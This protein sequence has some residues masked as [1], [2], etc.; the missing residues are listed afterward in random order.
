M[1]KQKNAVPKEI[2]SLSERYATSRRPLER[3]FEPSEF[4]HPVDPGYPRCR[5][6][7]ENMCLEIC[8]ALA[9]TARMTIFHSGTVV[10]DVA[11]TTEQEVYNAHVRGHA[12]EGTLILSL[13]DSLKTTLS[14]SQFLQFRTRT[15]DRTDGDRVFWELL[16]HFGRPSVPSHVLPVFAI[17]EAEKT[18]GR[19]LPDLSRAQLQS[20]GLI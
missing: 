14:W 7:R 19:P 2:V 13:L 16:R 10:R 11:M 9:T 4:L 6:G 15:R 3:A 12:Y 5:E 18:A 8:K 17:Y 1:S 20:L